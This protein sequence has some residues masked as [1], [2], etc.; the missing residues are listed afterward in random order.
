MRRLVCLRGYRVAWDAESQQCR[1]YRASLPKSIRLDV[2]ARVEPY[3]DYYAR[4]QLARLDVG[5]KHRVW[6]WLINA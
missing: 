1:L 3:E 6:I 4:Y 5:R 2:C